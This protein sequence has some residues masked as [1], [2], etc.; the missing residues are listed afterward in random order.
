M[1]CQRVK[2]DSSTQKRSNNTSRSATEKCGKAVHV[3]LKWLTLHLEI[4]K[5]EGVVRMSE[6]YEVGRKLGMREDRVDLALEFLNQAALILYYPKDVP[7]LVLTKMDP[8]TGRL[9]RL[10]KASFIP[11][12]NGPA[13]ESIELKAERSVQERVF[14]EGV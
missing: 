8:F 10:I 2:K 13:K 7:D 12:D 1:Q 3:P 6:C 9:S 11:P 4:D 14:E 5:G